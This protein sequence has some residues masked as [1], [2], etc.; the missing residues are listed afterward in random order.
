[1]FNLNVNSTTVG[2]LDPRKIFSVL[3][4][5]WLQQSKSAEV[6]F[7][8]EV[9]PTDA[10]NFDC[11]YCSYSSRRQSSGF[12]SWDLETGLRFAEFVCE[13]PVRTLC[14]SGGGEPL[15]WRP[16]PVVLE[17]L[18]GIPRLRKILITNG[19]LIGRR[20]SPEL[21]Q[22]FSLLVVSIAATEAKAYQ[23]TMRGAAHKSG[24]LE[25]VLGLPTLFCE[26]GPALNACVVVSRTNYQYLDRVAVD[27]V[28]RGFDF[29]YFKAQHNYEPLGERLSEERRERI[30]EAK[31]QLPPLVA[32]RTNLLTFIQDSVEKETR[33]RNRRPECINLQHMLNVTI[34]TAGDI[35]PC[36]S[37]IGDPVYSF[38]NVRTS[39]SMQPLRKLFLAGK[40]LQKIHEEYRAEQC[41]R[42]RF[43]RYNDLVLEA[44]QAGIS[45]SI[46]GIYE[47][48][49]FI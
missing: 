3:N 18:V 29:V 11:H 1:M 48:P 28:E 20:I 22:G 43:K 4:G 27:L 25:H 37:R 24:T 49:D 38:G 36:S 5:E 33:S 45:T 10:C 46:N 21:L 16:M 47:H 42:C 41:G 19:S 31:F 12:A 8:I 35:Y 14:L 40:M 13:K 6:P 17:R 32:E 26:P 2:Q 39:Q 9:Q 44:E 23:R 30:R 34:N 15:T 7:S